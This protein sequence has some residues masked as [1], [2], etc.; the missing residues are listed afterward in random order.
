S[1]LDCVEKLSQ[2]GLV[3]LK[4]AG[5]SVMVELSENAPE[6]TGE[7]SSATVRAAA[8][9]AA[10]APE[11]PPAP[12]VPLESQADGV[13]RASDILRAATNARWPMY[14]RNV[15]QLLRA[16]DGGFDERRYGF[17]GLVDLVRACQK[18]GLVRVE[19]DRRGGLRVFPGAA[20]PRIGMQRD[21]H[22]VE[23]PPAHARADEQR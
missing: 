1:F 16:A 6:E 13:K 22:P 21:I 11:A 17:G 8:A 18:E 9:S 14:L 3:N 23:T 19:R 2:G 5:Q 7:E 15:K 10:P 12:A 20:L 4:H